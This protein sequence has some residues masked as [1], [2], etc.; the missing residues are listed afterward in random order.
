MSCNNSC[1]NCYCD[2]TENSV[3]G[4][5]KLK[6]AMDFQTAIYYFELVEGSLVEIIQVDSDTH[7]ILIKFEETVSEWFHDDILDRLIKVNENSYEDSE[8][9]PEYQEF[10]PDKEYAV[11][12]FFKINKEV[13]KVT[14]DNCNVKGCHLCDFNVEN[15]EWYC[16]NFN[17][18]AGRRKDMRYTITIL[19]DTLED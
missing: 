16:T 9:I 1:N 5:Y 14:I 13:F 15:F 10:I 2:N 3:L 6:E 8:D 19:Y 11:G 4:L 12:E 7:K 18:E 17:C